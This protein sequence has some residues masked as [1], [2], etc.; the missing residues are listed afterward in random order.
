MQNLNC[1]RRSRNIV[2]VLQ[3][4]C[5]GVTLGLNI[6]PLHLNVNPETSTLQSH[7]WFVMRWT[8]TRLKWVPANYENISTVHLAPAKVWHPDM[9]VYNSVQHFDYETTD[10]LV[11]SDG[12]VSDQ[13]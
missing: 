10:L 7:V 6:I 13:E 9:M 8:D 11:T 2:F 1:L 3:C 4:C 12:T 5:R